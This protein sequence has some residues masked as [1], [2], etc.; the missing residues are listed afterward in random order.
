VKLQ[1]LSFLQQ[2]KEVF[3]QIVTPKIITAN[4]SNPCNNETVYKSK[5]VVGSYVA[6]SDLYKPEVTVLNELRNKLPQMSMLD[7]GVGAGRT[8][9]HF[10]YLV[11]EYVGLDCSNKMINACLEKFKN[12]RQK[13]SFLTADARNLK[14]FKSSSFDFVLFSFNGI[15]FMNHEERL[16]IL[17]EIRRL[18]KPGGYFCF[19]THNLNS[20][21]EQCSIRLSKHPT[22]LALRIR[23]LLQMRLLNKKEIW[24]ILRNPS[25]NQEYLRVN[26]IA[27]PEGRVNLYYIALVEQLKQLSELGFSDTKIYGLG[28]GNEIRN[29]TRAI[30]S[31][32]Y[33]LSKV[34]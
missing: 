15:D 12:N 24:R 5:D 22:L 28:D 26:I 33:F 30:D 23:Q 17:G 10:A 32:L 1:I 11:K 3:Q 16:K 27:N 14:L 9:T 21:I 13:F 19:S 25:R 20:L 4:G 34:P 7:I 18:I 8:T 2:I 31:W 29:P 6:K